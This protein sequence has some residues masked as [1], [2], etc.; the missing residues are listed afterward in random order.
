MADILL[1]AVP[2]AGLPVDHVYLQSDD[3]TLVWSCFGRSTG[4]KPIAVLRDADLDAARRECPPEG[5]VQSPTARTAS[6][7]S[8]QTEYLRQ[9]QSRAALR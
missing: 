3:A 7:T 8:K 4:G 2:V 9:P 5:P 1:M 6:C